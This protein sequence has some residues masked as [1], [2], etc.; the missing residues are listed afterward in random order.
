MSED[1]DEL[2][3]IMKMVFDFG[4]GFDV[5]CPEPSEEDIEQ[6]IQAYTDR[7]ILKELKTLWN[8]TQPEIVPEGWEPDGT[9]LALHERIKEWE[10]QL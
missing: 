2:D 5:G 1:T 10:E 9:G 7:Q 4:S 8:K 3:N 6:A